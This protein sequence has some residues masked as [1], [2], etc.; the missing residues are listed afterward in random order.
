MACIRST[1]GSS[2]VSVLLVVTRWFD[3]RA[4]R[5]AMGDFPRWIDREDVDSAAMYSAY[6]AY[7]NFMKEKYSHITGAYRPVWDGHLHMID[8]RKPSIEGIFLPRDVTRVRQV[9]CRQQPC[10]RCDE[11][12][13][14]YQFRWFS[15]YWAKFYNLVRREGSWKAPI[16]DDEAATSASLRFWEERGSV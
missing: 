7:E 3:L 15:P 16:G 12:R 14:G 6:L 10:R 5:L 1:A 2:E 11:K 4:Y 8:H 9:D 13:G